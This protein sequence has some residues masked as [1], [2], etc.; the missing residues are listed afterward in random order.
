[1]HIGM[2]LAVA[3]STAVIPPADLRVPGRS[4]RNALTL[5]VERLL[6]WDSSAF[7]LMAT[8]SLGRAGQEIL[9][10]ALDNSKS[11]KL[12][13]SGDISNKAYPFC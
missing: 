10:R 4:T 3:V 5:G 12:S 2:D 11:G 1:M 7:N 8:K 13:K 9:H 6:G